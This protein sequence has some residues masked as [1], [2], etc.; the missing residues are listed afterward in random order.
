MSD[1]AD[2]QTDL[3]IENCILDACA[4]RGPDKSVCPSEI[5]RELDPQHW[6]PL[7]PPVRAVAARLTRE[8]RIRTT[9]GGVDVDAESAGGP[10]RLHAA[11]GLRARRS[12]PGIS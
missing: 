3:R 7:M 5:A 8:G 2:P 11:H 4:A 1:D 6:R 12:V 9:R 10:I